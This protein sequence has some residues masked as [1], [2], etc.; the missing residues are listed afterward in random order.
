MDDDSYEMLIKLN[1]EKVRL[2]RLSEIEDARLLAVKP[3]RTPVE[4]CWMFSSSLPLWLLEKNPL[5]DMITYLDADLYFYASLEPIY[6]EFGH[7]SIM[8]IPHGFPENNK[9]QEKTR[10]IYNVGMTIFRNDVNGLAALRWWKDRVIEWCFDRYENGKFG[11]QLYLNDWTTRFNGVHV[12]KNP[13]ANVA[14]WNIEAFRCSQAR[15]IFYHFHGLKIYRSSNGKIRAYPST[16]HDCLIY[17][18]YLQVMEGAYQSISV[19]QPGW[20]FGLAKKLDIFRII[21]QYIGL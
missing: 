13:G 7:S 10:G 14:S 2:L 4:Y 21:K 11:D 19:P 5:L 16:V 20:S 17:K 9:W 1:L 12:L 8:I 15:L 6:E 18:P 3:T